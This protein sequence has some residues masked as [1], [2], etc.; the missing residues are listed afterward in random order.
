[1]IPR[2]NAEQLPE[3]AAWTAHNVDVTSGALTPLNIK[4]PFASMRDSNGGLLA[5]V[6]AGDVG[7]IKKPDAPTKMG[8]NYICNPQTW[9]RVWARDWVSSIASDGT[10]MVSLIRADELALNVAMYT[11]EGFYLEGWIDQG[12]RQLFVKSDS[13]Y[14]VRGPRYQFCFSAD[15]AN[16]GPNAAL[17]LP[18][19]TTYADPE[20]PSQQVPLVDANGNIYAHWQ[21]TDVYGPRNDQD[22]FV[23]D[24]PQ[25]YYRPQ[26]AWVIFKVNL[27]YADTRRKH[28]YFVQS[29][30]TTFG[31]EGPPSE[32]SSRIMIKPGQVL[33]LNTPR[34]GYSE[35]RLYCSQTGGDD[36]LLVGDVNADH[37]Q[38]TQTMP[39]TQN[40]IIPPFG[41]YPG[42]GPDDTNKQT[43]LKGSLIHPAGFA[44]A[45]HEKTVH[46]SDFYRFHS[47]PD[48][49]TVPF[50]QTVQAIAMSGNTILVFVGS[51]ET[52]KVF[53]VAGSNPATM[54]KY[55]LSETACLLTI[56]SLCRINQTVF[57]ATYDGLAA[58]TGSQLQI[59]TNGHFNREQWLTLSPDKMEAVTADN[60]IFIESQYADETTLGLRFD[61][62]ETLNA[63]TSYSAKSGGNLTWRSKRFWFDQET[64]FDYVRVIADSYEPAITFRI[65]GDRGDFTEFAIGSDDFV[66]LS[67]LTHAHEWQFEIKNAETTIRR[68]ELFDRVL[69]TVTDFTTHLTEANTLLWRCIW[70]KFP[71][72]DRFVAGT[73]AA[74]GSGTV[75]IK[76]Y[77]DGKDDPIDEGQIVSCKKDASSG[78]LF[79]LPRTLADGT[80]W[81]VNVDTTKHVNELLLFT[82]QTQLVSGNIHEINAGPFPPW[83][84]KRYE[85]ADQAEPTSLIVHASKVVKIN[86]YFDGST[87]PSQTLTNI[88]SGI[89]LRLDYGRHSSIEFDFAGNDD[90]VTEVLVFASQ[91]EIIGGEGITLTNSPAWRRRLF[92]FPDQGRFVCGSVGATSYPEDASEDGPIKLHLYGN[93]DT[94]DYGLK[95]YDGNL[96][97]LGRG[98]PESAIWEVDVESS[99][100]IDSVILLPRQP[101]PIQGKDIHVANPGT[102]PSW[103]YSRYE[104][105]EP[106][107]LTSLM[108]NTE[109]GGAV[110]INLYLDGAT[111]KYGTAEIV[112]ESG[113]EYPL[114]LKVPPTCNSIEF[115]FSG[116]DAKVT[117]V[118]IFGRQVQVIGENGIALSNR[119]NWRNL[120]FA[121]PKPNT[122]VCAVLGAKGYGDD[123]TTTTIDFYADGEKANLSYA[124][125]DGRPFQF[126]RGALPKAVAWVVDVQCGAEI[127]HLFLIPS[128]SVA[129]TSIVR[130]SGDA[131]IPPWLYTQYEF[132]DMV[133][134]RSATVEAT[135]YPLWMQIFINGN[136]NCSQTKQIDSADE[137]ALNIG[138]VCGAVEFRFLD[139]NDG[140]PIGT[141]LVDY[142]VKEVRIF[143]EE[144][145]PIPNYGLVLRDGSSQLAWRNKTLRFADIGSFSVGRVVA[146]D[147]T[148]LQL[149]LSANGTDYGPIIILDS[150]EFKFKD[151]LEDGVTLPN[152]RDWQLD[153]KHCGKISELL[154]IGCQQY[155]VNSGLVRVRYEQDP[156]TWLDKRVVATR[157]ICFTCG[158]VLAD[159]YGLTLKLYAGGQLQIT[160][161]VASGDAFRLPQ[162]RPEREWIID[163]VPNSDDPVILIHEMALATSMSRLD[164]G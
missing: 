29:L 136:T 38:F 39:I 161:T 116:N 23:R 58:A 81:R 93:G 4:G 133:K 71:H 64:I 59:V 80:F 156:F 115:E 128:R 14:Y 127:D 53:G 69:H 134:L 11:E 66:R 159:G 96:F 140:V 18:A 163:L 111:D 108:V 150:Q 122:F 17:T 129:V 98:A 67:D 143:A 100:E 160:K 132:P 94:T 152:A 139:Y 65:A 151:K 3:G 103:L 125:S 120:H 28:Y 51:G 48:I 9:L 24:Y 99:V 1:M 126:P 54:T 15:P 44:V 26:P 8:L 62:D 7:Y 106:T 34:S 31:A 113:V 68:V 25:M 21:I 112:L 75:S 60:S 88:V 16:G 87:E 79:T 90:A 118:H 84:V 107:E 73:I 27:N 52:G 85:F 5:G 141:N 157:P 78:A 43:F 50:Q 19:A 137:V 74:Q 13:P 110:T 35:N 83:L 153:I 164:Y 144:Y 32:L 146:S 91:P 46:F 41:N 2:L 12:I 56:K 155:T 42:A 57:W 37:W 6:P 131:A 102:I 114:E 86:L 40:E 158:R 104:F 10:W 97:T 20:I 33:A 109:G 147:Y 121:F 148:G 82:R 92:K 162:K 30:I 95:I 117:N 22:F 123:D 101:V 154:F 119:I 55:L 145:V 135:E 77:A 138:S 36:F 76:F 49:N 124:I 45:F 149:T 72:K 63:V 130:A 105:N 142:T 61:L 70:L 47:W 89:E